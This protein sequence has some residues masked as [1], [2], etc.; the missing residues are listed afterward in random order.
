MLEGR[1]DL[2][3]A[4]EAARAFF[5]L[6]A[7]IPFF[8]SRKKTEESSDLDIILIKSSS[9][10]FRITPSAGALLSLKYSLFY[11]R[12]LVTAQQLSFSTAANNHSNN[13]LSTS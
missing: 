5:L 2:P 6:V 12:L 7:S 1:G 8:R 13:N 3:F 11:S 9:P 10:C 4:L